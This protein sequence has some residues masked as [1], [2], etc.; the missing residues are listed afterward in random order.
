LPLPSRRFRWRGARSSACTVS[1]IASKANKHSE[2]L[3]PAP[4]CVCA[5]ARACVRACVRACLCV[6][7]WACV[8]VRAHSHG[9]MCAWVHAWVG[10]GAGSGTR[11]LFGREQG[12][13]TAIRSE[14]EGLVAHLA[15]GI[16]KLTADR[17]PA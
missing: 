13:S 15:K 11:S 17:N 7:V 4:V 1:L 14:G 2:Q 3:L 6:R 10:G 5:R 8:C 12:R 16:H 9:W